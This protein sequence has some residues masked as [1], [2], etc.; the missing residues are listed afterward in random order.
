L[1]PGAVTLQ[2]QNAAMISL[3]DFPQHLQSLKKEDWSKLFSILDE[4]TTDTHFGEMISPET[5]PDG[6]NQFPY[7]AWAP[8]VSRFVEVVYELEIIVH[9]NW[10]SWQEGKAL[11][12]NPKTNYDRLDNVTLCKLLTVIVRADRFSEG[13]LVGSFENGVIQKIIKGIRLEIF[14]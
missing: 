3:E 10:S 1:S 2:L 6:T 7:Y 11:L 9:F 8:V 12:E 4:I 14:G 13:T 5:L